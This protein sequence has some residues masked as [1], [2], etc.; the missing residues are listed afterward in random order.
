MEQ[1]PP[2][3]P[4]PPDQQRRQQDADRHRR[5]RAAQPPLHAQRRRE[6]D[7][8]C[9]SLRFANVRVASHRVACQ[10]LPPQVATPGAPLLD[11]THS[12]GQRTFFCP[13]CQAQKFQ[14]E[15][16][17]TNMCCDKGQ[18]CAMGDLFTMP[19]PEPL[20]NYLNDPAK[21]RERNLLKQNSRG[22]NNALAMASTGAHFTHPR[23]GFSMI[24]VSGAIHHLLGPLLPTGTA[25]HRFSQ[26]YIMDP[27]AALRRR[28]DILGLGG[29]PSHADRVN[30][31]RDLQN[32]L[33]NCNL[34]VRTYQQARD[35][36]EEEA[37]DF[38][39]V[40]NTDGTADM[41]RYNAPTGVGADQLGGLIPGE[42]SD[43]TRHA[44]VRGR[45]DVLN[46]NGNVP[47]TEIHDNHP[48]FAPLRYP[49]MHP[50]GEPGW[51][52]RTILKRPSP[53]GQRRG[54]APAMQA[55]EDEGDVDP[56]EDVDMGEEG[57]A[58]PGP[59][60]GGR[61]R[62]THVTYHE[63]VVWYMHDRPRSN[64]YFMKFGTLSQEWIIDQCGVIQ[65]QR[66]RWCALNQVTLRAESYRGAR[67]AMR[68][69]DDD[70]Q[71]IGTHIVLPATFVG[72]PRYYV[73]CYQYAMAI[74]RKFGKPDLF[75][76]MTCNPQW[77]EIQ[78]ELEPGAGPND[79]VDLIARV[80]KLKLD[81]LLDDVMKKG[82]FGRVIGHVHVIEFQK[83]GLPHAHIL[84]ILANEDKPRGPADYDAM[85]CAE[86]PDPATHPA[87]YKVVTGS[88]LH[89]PCGG[90]H[91]TA[92]CMKNGECS[93]RYPRP[94]E[95]ETVESRNG[96]PVYRR[97]DHGRTHTKQGF[98]FD[99]TR[100]IPYNPWLSEKYACHI[101][102]EVCSPLPP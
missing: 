26:I 74:V 4:P 98:E 45:V 51:S 5:D 84:V 2:P 31:L 96:Y 35:I 39:F 70:V 55:E 49:F 21:I 17:R 58:P 19:P 64:S 16:S 65:Q 48:A 54:A 91:P 59:R 1:P 85:V 69:G 82:V 42:G 38:E 62:Q 3:A 90:A 9:H 100:V 43:A 53:P 7:A 95:E 68:R 94:F 24:A 23:D 34:Y 6:A 75:I 36:P 57:G 72:G 40:I 93:K 30:M 10:P 78:R 102:V 20:N 33:W 73:Q 66:L 25:A 52:P 29:D 37:P 14:A 15:L 27:H 47:L 41:R 80:F 11:P 97:R 83:R 46:A 89:G 12:I 13:Y 44:R 32:M 63:H 28:M 8:R 18:N 99:N 60:Q 86:I 88:M 101:N 92:V 61:G 67:D 56:D 81:A 22:F 76:T 77:E 87:L 50:R 71:N 79:R